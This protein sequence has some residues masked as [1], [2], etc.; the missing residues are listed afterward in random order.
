M[1]LLGWIVAG[2]MG[3]AIL[4]LV[5]EVAV[6]F[7]LLALALALIKA[8]QNTLMVLL[9]LALL[10]AFSRHPALGFCLMLGVVTA[11]S[12]TPGQRQ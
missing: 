12:V 10:E 6:L 4:R 9:S 3:L 7:L 5:L 2:C 11:G 1:R 8:P